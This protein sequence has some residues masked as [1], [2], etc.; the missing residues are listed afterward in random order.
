MSWAWKAPVVFMLF[1]PVFSHAATLA[2]LQ[3]QLAALM[4]QLSVLQSHQATVV[5][6]QS[7]ATISCLNLTRNLSYGSRGSDVV[8]LQQFLISQ[9]LLGTGNDTGY[10]GKLTQTAVRNFQCKNNIVCSGTSATT[11]YGAVGPRTRAAIARVCSSGSSI[12]T[13]SPLSTP[14]PPTVPNPPRS[15]CTADA[16][17][18]P[19][20]SYVERSGLNCDFVACP[21][22]AS[23][24]PL[25]SQTQT[26][27][28]PS[29]QTGSITQTRTSSCPGL[30]WGE[31]KTTSKICTSATATLTSVIMSRTGNIRWLGFGYNQDPLDRDT[32]GLDRDTWEAAHWQITEARV[33]ALSP[34]FVRV[35]FNREWFNPSGQIGSYDWNSPSMKS[36]YMVFDLY[37]SLHIPVMTGLWH[38]N[39]GQK[40]DPAFYASDDF[41]TLQTDLMQHLNQKGYTNISWFSPTNEPLGAAGITFDIWS[42]MIRKVSPRFV[43]AGFT[44]ILSGPDSWAPWTAWTAQWNSAQV[45][46]YDHHYYLNQGQSEL[47]SGTFEQNMMRALVDVH[48]HDATKPTFLS[49]LGAAGASDGAIDYWYQKSNPEITLDSYDYGL[50]IFDMGI[51]AARAGESGAL[52]WCLDGFDQGKD[53]GMWNIGGLHGGTTLRPWFY[54]WSLL[55]KYF[56]A[57]TSELFVMSQPERVRILG[58]KIHTADETKA[59]Y[60]FAAVNR[61]SSDVNVTFTTAPYHWYRGIFDIYTYQLDQHGDGSSPSLTPTLITV[62]DLAGSDL[63]VKVPAHGGVVVTSVNHTTLSS[64]F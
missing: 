11:G 3:T 45:S 28:C 30:M 6:P 8:Q 10:F 53:C 7:G 21:T 57:Q 61:G 37:K 33:R 60:S 51:Q 48:V 1:L 54:T 2:E 4:Q 24:A 40:D 49:E 5:A 44:A 23:C 17:Q 50:A 42:S 14:T 20:G 55:M 18:C 35:N 31:W 34:A 27:S 36:A 15:M 13:I 39:L 12:P 43:S 29:G 47:A 25:P 38:S 9:N 56:P 16:K 41:A 32:Q 62:A 19:D 63:I 52:A 46:A 58:A 59:H 64:E 22:T 26:L